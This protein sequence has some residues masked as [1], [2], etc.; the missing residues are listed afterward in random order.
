M[1][2][3]ILDT[4]ILLA[5]ARQSPPYLNAEKS[6]NLSADDAQLIVSVVSLVEIRVLAIRNNWGEKKIE[7][8]NR[9]FEETLLVVDVSIGA[10]ELLDAYVEIDVQSNKMGRKMGKND[11]WIAATA[12]VTGSTLI[13]TDKNF[14]HL[15]N[16]HL[17]VF[18]IV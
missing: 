3:F 5:Y 7:L 17:S 16:T 9:L 10:P 2:K 6:L 11:L 18:K 12:K 8:L 15:N 14:D 4:N 13:S 1:R